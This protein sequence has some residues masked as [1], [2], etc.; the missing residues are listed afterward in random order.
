MKKRIGFIA[1][2]QAGGNIGQLFEREGYQ[3]LY[4]NT[5]QE[6]LDTLKDAKYKHHIENGEG[7]N[8]DR[9]KAKQLLIDD[10]DNIATKVETVFSCDL[11]YVI[12]GAGGGTG[13]GAAPMLIDLLTDDDKTV[14]AIVIMPGTDESVK[15]HIN[16]YEAFSELISIQ[17]TI[18]SFILDN[19]KGDKL[20]INKKFV[21]DFCSFVDIPNKHKS[22]KGNIDKAEIMETL[23][24]HGMAY[25]VDSQEKEEGAAGVINLLTDNIY[26]P[27]EE[28][29]TV[30]YIAISISGD[31]NV[32]DLETAIGT[33][34][35]TYVTYNDS[36][37]ICC[38]AGLSYP[39]TRLDAVYKKIEDNKDT[40]MKNLAAT[41]ETK[42]K[43]DVNFLDHLGNNIDVKPSKE[44]KPKS[45]RDIMSKYLK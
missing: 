7:C 30:K 1:L 6:D 4:I 15:S 23:K 34:L 16:A 31:I 21:S 45:K 17:G 29:K 11:L 33:P 13:S 19:D 14:G 38:L 22:V 39:Q 10:Y 18:S 35:D 27:V 2:G 9:H 3:V 43:T 36:S 41:Q 26:A 25:I 32:T 5:S 28:D 44:N 20:D 8:K 40:V 37:T 42:L 24:S 12:F